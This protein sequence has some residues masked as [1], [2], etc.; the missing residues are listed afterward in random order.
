MEALNGK[1]K[2]YLRGLAHPLPPVVLIGREGVTEGV[3]K[4]LD[5]ALEDHELLK[6]KFN[7]FKESKGEL[8]QEMAARTEAA[9][10]G[11]VGHVAILYRPRRE[12]EKR[13]IHLPD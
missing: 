10:A 5:Q 1:Q 11:V 6:V 12:E 8:L 13:R 9:V 3:L 2:K 4:A 7:E